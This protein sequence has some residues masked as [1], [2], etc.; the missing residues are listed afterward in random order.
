MSDPLYAPWK[1]G[2]PIATVTMSEPD[3]MSVRLL[4]IPYQAPADWLPLKRTDFGKVMDHI[5]TKYPMPFTCEIIET[6]GTRTT[7][8]VDLTD[9]PAAT[10]PTQAAQHAR[11]AHPSHAAPPPAQPVGEPTPEASWVR[12]LDEPEPA[13][14]PEAS[15][16]GARL[17]SLLGLPALPPRRRE[18]EA[19]VAA[20]GFEP[21]EQVAVGLVVGHVAAD[22]Q[23]RAAVTLPSWVLANLV[24]GEAVLAGLAS[25]RSSV[26][27]GDAGR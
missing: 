22:H 26:V 4:G 1:E 19:V 9:T 14:I 12:L 21:G 17:E 18:G 7:G 25:A 27:R 24:T 6:D 15:G 23:G 10:A 16:L 11:Q 5:Y 3:L 20:Y 13:P 2:D 8:V